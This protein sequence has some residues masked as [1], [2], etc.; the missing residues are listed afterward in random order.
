MRVYNKINICI[1]KF[2]SKISNKS[3][4][5]QKIPGSNPGQV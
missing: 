5:D 1:I 2:T 3:V 4:V